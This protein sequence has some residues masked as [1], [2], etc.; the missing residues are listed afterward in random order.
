VKEGRA[1]TLPLEQHGQRASS[2][3]AAENGDRLDLAGALSLHNFAAKL[4]RG[5]LENNYKQCWV[6]GDSVERVYKSTMHQHPSSREHPSTNDQ[7]PFQKSPVTDPTEDGL[8]S[9]ISD[10]AAPFGA[11]INGADQ[12][13]V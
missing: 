5:F 10:V 2:R 11:S 8:V 9:A 6:F 4:A 13:H 3:A 12:Q 7:I 1:D